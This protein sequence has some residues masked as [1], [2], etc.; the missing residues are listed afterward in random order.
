[1]KNPGRLPGFMIET[2]RFAINSITNQYCA[3]IIVS[4]FG[5]VVSF[6]FGTVSLAKLIAVTA[7]ECLVT[8]FLSSR[9]ARTTAADNSTTHPNTTFFIISFLR[10]FNDVYYPRCF[11]NCA[12]ALKIQLKFFLAQCVEN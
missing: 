4:F 3:S 1:M 8:F 11:N 2:E 10:F 6:L 9:V 5:F 12:I 7:H